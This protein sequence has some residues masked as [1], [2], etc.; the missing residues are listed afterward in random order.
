MTTIRQ[1]V[2][3]LMERQLRD[4]P[5]LRQNHDRLKDVRLKSWP[6]GGFSLQA[7][8]NPERITSSAARVDSHSISERACFLCTQHRPP[9]EEHVDA[10]NGYE[11]LCNPYPIFRDHFTIAHREHTPQVIDGEFSRMLELSRMLPDLVVFYNAPSCGASAPDHMHFQAG[12]REFMPIGSQAGDLVLRYGKVLAGSAAD[13][14]SAVNDGL[15]RMILV[16]SGNMPFLEQVF[17]TISSFLRKE[18]G[19]EEPMLN[20]LS[21]HDKRWKVFFFPRRAHRPAQYFLKGKDKILF[22]PASVDLGG[23]LILPREGDFEKITGGDIRDMFGQ[24]VIGPDRFE[25]LCRKLE[26]SVVK[27]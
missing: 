8:Y 4:W 23:T 11:I 20:I 7:Q 26:Q 15:R 25:A 16:E 1:Q 3:A 19:G 13:R 21:Y 5:L 17:G 9:E 10:G 2:R 22:S 14:L 27:V 12:S 18:T 6:F 24:V